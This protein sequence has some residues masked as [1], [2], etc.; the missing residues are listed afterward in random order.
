MYLTPVFVARTV[1]DSSPFK[2]RNLS[3][4]RDFTYSRKSCLSIEF[5]ELS[6]QTICA[7][8]IIESYPADIASEAVGFVLVIHIEE[9]NTIVSDLVAKPTMRLQLLPFL[10]AQ[11]TPVVYKTVVTS[12]DVFLESAMVFAVHPAV[13]VTGVIEK[14]VDHAED[15]SMPRRIVFFYLRHLGSK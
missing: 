1:N 10:A 8:N 13:G 3:P 7:N 5:I 9:D 12:T 11:F 14:S 2:V 4:S 15:A 6:C